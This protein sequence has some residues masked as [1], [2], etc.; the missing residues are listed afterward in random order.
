MKQNRVLSGIAGFLPHLLMAYSWMMLTF[1][2]INTVNDSMGFLS[3]RTSRHFELVYF[4]VC[5]L[6]A[7]VAFV[8]KKCRIPAAVTCAAGIAMLVP[9]IKAMAQDSPA[10]L[11]TGYFNIIAGV[12][13]VL[14]LGF[15][16]ALI[17][18][19]RIAAKKAES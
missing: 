5:V 6:T 16:I 10:P 9:V 7:V 14:T 1:A 11:T 2:V 12:F 17:V 18:M 8:Q 4:V 13:G 15:S 19:Q 3:S